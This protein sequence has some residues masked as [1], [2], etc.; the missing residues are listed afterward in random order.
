[1]A[2][3]SVVFPHRGEVFLVNFDPTIG[4]EI[5]KTR[6]A[7]I[8]QQDILNEYSPV[9]IVAAITSKVG[10]KTYPTEVPI[11]LKEGGLAVE[12]VILCN[13]I[14]TI[15]KARLVQKLGMVSGATM[16]R[17]SYALSISLGMSTL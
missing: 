2:K 14:R 17:V 6:P 9:T 4:A 1:M 15:D 11:P 13:Q 5:Q 7:L 10:D 12:S 16:K 3:P 8:L